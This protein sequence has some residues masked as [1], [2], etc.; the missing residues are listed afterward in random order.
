MRPPAAAYSERLGL[1]AILLLGLAARLMTVLSL[2]IRPESDFHAYHTM[3]LNLLDG[4]EIADNMGNR[5]MYNVGYPLFVIAPLL[6]LFGPDILSVQ[7]GNAV[8]GTLGVFL[9]YAVARD[10]GIG[11]AGRLL[12][13]L[14]WAIYVP[15]W[16]YAEYLAKENLMTPLMLG[17]MWCALQLERR[18]SAAIAAACGLLFGFL[19][20]VGNAG[21]VLVPVAA[22]ALLIA[23]FGYRLKI[24]AFSIAVGVALAVIAPWMIRNAEVLG[25]PVL[26]TNGGFNL[27]LGNNP[28]A[29]GYF[30]SIAD[31]PRGPTWEAL[32]KTGEVRASQILKDEA[33]DWIRD[34]PLQFAQLAYRKAVLF[35]TPPIHAGEG[36]GSRTETLVRFVWLF[37]F[38]VLAAG[39]V[40]SV[41]VHAGRTRHALILWLA[42][43]GY[44][45]VHML[46]Y[47]VYRYREPI[48]PLL[49]VLAA[50]FLDALWT[51]WGHHILARLRNAFSSPGEEL[52]A[53]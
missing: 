49:C 45:A 9:C 35:W 8:L 39:A 19:A 31:T 30:V 36:S 41:F 22:I 17:I 48:M 5:A 13:A 14:A 26:N 10:L 16:L 3:A 6:A 1:L 12:A 42:I 21:L 15:S 20:L 51:R 7:V 46:F 34:K 43:A 4:R 24:V 47:V 37:E 18:P 29:N 40:G 52:S 38:M 50:A 32:R 2:D 53:D 23:R 33:I 28:M 44:T 25:A 27:Y 11:R